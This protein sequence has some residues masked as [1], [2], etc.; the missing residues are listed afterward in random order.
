MFLSTTHFETDIMTGDS[1]HRD[2]PGLSP[3]S[4]STADGRIRR[5]WTRPVSAWF[6][7]VLLWSAVAATAVGL[8]LAGA[9]A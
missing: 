9:S 5:R 3:A 1:R 6:F 7:F 4:H 2:D 8:Y